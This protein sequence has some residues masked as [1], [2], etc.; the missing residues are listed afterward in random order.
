MIKYKKIA[1][2]IFS[3]IN[4][5]KTN[6]SHTTDLSYGTLSEKMLQVILRSITMQ[7]TMLK[8]Q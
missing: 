5:L 2:N 7:R 6:L 4:K 8:Y 3:H 1:P